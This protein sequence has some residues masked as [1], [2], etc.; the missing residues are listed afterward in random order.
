M[1]LLLRMFIFCSTAYS[2]RDGNNLRVEQERPKET[3]HVYTMKSYITTKNDAE[4][5]YILTQK[6]VYNILLK[7]VKT[8]DCIEYSD[9]F[10]KKNRSLVNW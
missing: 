4:E 1:I 5:I 6:V 2:S 7:K 10:G 9:L 3:M 8:A